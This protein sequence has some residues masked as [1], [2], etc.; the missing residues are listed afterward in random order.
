MQVTVFMYQLL[1]GYLCSVTT[2]ERL[3]NKYTEVE[4]QR[5]MGKAWE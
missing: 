4:E 3:G 5:K 2:R 1:G